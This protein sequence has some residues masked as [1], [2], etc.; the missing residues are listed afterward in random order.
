MTMLALTSSTSG[1]RSVGIVCLRTK[2]HGVC[3]LLERSDYITSE[4][5]L[6]GYGARNAV[7]SVLA[8]DYTWGVI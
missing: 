1:C 5:R 2:S 4:D 3:F 7:L 8:T 6:L